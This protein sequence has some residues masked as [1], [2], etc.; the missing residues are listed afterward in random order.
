MSNC[1]K[2]WI[3]TSV[4]PPKVLLHPHVTM[5]SLVLSGLLSSASSSSS[6]E[7]A[8][9]V[10]PRAAGAW[11][12]LCHAAFQRGTT[13]FWGREVPGC[14]DSLAVVMQEAVTILGDNLILGMPSAAAFLS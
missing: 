11:G 9:V 14:P 6:Q 5:C 8:H 7:D 13:I 10:L 4:V 3:R 1:R 2:I 12:C